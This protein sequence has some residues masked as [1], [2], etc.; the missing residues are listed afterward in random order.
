MSLQG[1]CIVRRRGERN[2]EVSPLLITR[3]ARLSS[4]VIALS[5]STGCAVQPGPPDESSSAEQT[6]PGVVYDRLSDN[7][8]LTV[9]PTTVHSEASSIYVSYK[10]TVVNKSQDSFPGFYAAFVLDSDLD[11]YL[12]AGVAPIPMLKVD[13]FP[14]GAAE[15][16]NGSGGG[17]G[18]ELTSDQLVSDRAFLDDAE[19]DARRILELGETVTLWLR[20]NGGEERLEYTTRVLD[21]DNLL[22]S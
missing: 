4:L 12:A 15:L 9:Y 18:A 7:F 6:L 21:P 16:E 11:Q 8:T 19:L 14:A 5:L 1:T 22:G 3:R 13:L 20:W 10:A 17:L 2:S